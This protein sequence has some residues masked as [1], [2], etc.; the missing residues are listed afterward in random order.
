[1]ANLLIGGQLSE[2]FFEL[3]AQLRAST[4][5]LANKVIPGGARFYSPWLCTYPRFGTP[6]NLALL[7]EPPCERGGLIIDEQYLAHA[8][9]WVNDI[10]L[11]HQSA[12]TVDSGEVALPGE[13]HTWLPLET[14]SERI[15]DLFR[16][17]KKLLLASDP[18]MCRQYLEMIDFVVPIFSPGKKNRGFSHH[19]ARGIIFRSFPEEATIWDVGID[20]AHEL[21]HQT[22][23]VWQSADAILTSPKDAPVYSFIR[24]ANR[25]AIQ[26]FHA[27]VALAYMLSFTRCYAD[28]AD[29]REVAARRGDW[30]VDTLDKSLRLS[31]ESLRANCTFTE[32]GD[33]LMQE[34]E[35]LV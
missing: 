10:V 15:M 32:L 34:M 21:G 24:K 27:A 6:P 8:R 14:V 28:E 17:G 4:R 19:L 7:E 16:E 18:H 29:C 5:E 20:L 30:Y 11:F 13:P 25:P 31:L 26:T 12:I 22:L 35:A 1:M 9:A 23:F 3:N 2:P 33:A